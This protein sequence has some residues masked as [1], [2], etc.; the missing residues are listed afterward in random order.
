M[1]TQVHIFLIGFIPKAISK[2]LGELH[3]EI[4]TFGLGTVE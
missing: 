4:V 1:V 3:T 2:E